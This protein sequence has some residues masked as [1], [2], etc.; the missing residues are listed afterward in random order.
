M[1]VE[2][3]ITYQTKLL[4]WRCTCPKA[5]PFIGKKG[6]GLYAREELLISI[7]TVVNNGRGIY[8]ALPEQQTVTDS[9]RVLD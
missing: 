9:L 1:F 4:L 2:K 7:I 6:F 5:T 8:M 3:W